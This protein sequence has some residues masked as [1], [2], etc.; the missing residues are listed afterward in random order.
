MTSARPSRLFWLRQHGFSAVTGGAQFAS[1]RPGAEHSGHGERKD[2]DPK[3]KFATLPT[4]NRELT[5]DLAAVRRDPLRWSRV[6][7]PVWN[8]RH[9][10]AG[11]LRQQTEH[12]RARHE[13]DGSR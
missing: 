7:E 4:T 1:S 5:V 2:R 3:L 8:D 9:S 6:S 10:D 11:V 12:L 13:N